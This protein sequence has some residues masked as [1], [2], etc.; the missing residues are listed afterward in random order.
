MLTIEVVSSNIFVRSIGELAQRYFYWRKWV[1]AR[2][3]HCR[4]NTKRKS[5][6]FLFHE[7]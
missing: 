7:I 6:L 1:S 4:K 2:F 5:P 3:F